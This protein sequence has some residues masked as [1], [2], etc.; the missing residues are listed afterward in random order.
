M[1]EGESQFQMNATNMIICNLISGILLESDIVR[2]YSLYSA[3]KMNRSPT[4]DHASIS[5][6]ILVLLLRQPSQEFE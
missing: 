3:T 1:Q 6:A 2:S 5:C 4:F